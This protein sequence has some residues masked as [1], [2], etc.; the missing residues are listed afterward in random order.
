V[1]ATAE[2]ASAVD[3]ITGLAARSALLADLA[4]AVTPGSRTSLL[5]V[6]ALDGLR[7]FEELHGVIEG[8]KLLRRLSERLSAAVEGVGTGYHPRN[9]EFAILV[10]GK[11]SASAIL[12]ESVAALSEADRYYSVVAT[13]GHAVLPAEASEPIEALIVADKRLTNSS[14]RRAPRRVDGR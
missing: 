2:K 4:D 7:E 1:G 8:R 5:A 13:V 9:D 12:A 14:P 10:T 11:V 3:P 6:F